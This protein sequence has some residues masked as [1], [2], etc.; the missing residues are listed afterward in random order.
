MQRLLAQ[1]GTLAA[2]TF[3]S[4]APSAAQVEEWGFMR[5]ERRVTLTFGPGTAPLVLSL[6]TDAKRALYART[7]PADNPA[8][9]I[10]AVPTEFLRELPVAAT[11]WRERLLRELPAGAKI[12]AVKL[13]KLSDNSTLLDVALDDSG[14]P[15]SEIPNPKSL[16]ALLAALRTLR[17]AEFAADHFAEKFFAAGEERPWKYRLAA[18]LSLPGGADGQLAQTELLLLERT[19]GAQQFAGSRE[20]DTIFAIE[21]PLLDALWAFTEGPRD[22]GPAPEVKK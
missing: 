20:F 8:A 21:Q 9:A 7:G 16:V 4:D 12:T 2:T 6:G 3:V 15:K 13:T 17:A 18:S 1:L 10:S 11:A 22:P 19:G 14:N 5:P